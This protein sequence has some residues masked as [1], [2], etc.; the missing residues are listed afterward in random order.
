L[1]DPVQET[2]TMGASPS[3]HPSDQRL[4]AY[5]NGKLDEASA[6]AVSKHLDGCDECLNKVAGIQS[7]SFLGKLRQVHLP[8]VSAAGGNHATGGPETDPGRSQAAPLETEGVP[9]ELAI[10]LDYQIV[11]KLGE[12]GMGVV[13]LARNV[14]M[15][16]D[17]VLKLM[18]STIIER[19]DALDRFQREIRAVARMRHPNI[20][21]AYRAFRAGDR[22]VFAMEYVEG[23]DL[24]RMV[25]ARMKTGKGPLPVANACYYAYQAA[26]ALQHAH[27]HGMVH[28]DIKPANLMLA[29]KGDQ[30]II[31]VLDFGLSKATL[32]TTIL[33]PD[34]PSST[35]ILDGSPTIFGQMLGT[36][37]YIAPEQI[38]DAQSADIRADVY[39][40]GCTLYY[41]LSGRPPFRAQTLYDMLQAHQS[42]SADLLNFVRPEVPTELAA[43]VA[44]MMAKE[45]THRF[46]TPSEVAGALEPFFRKQAEPSLPEPPVDASPP[47][48]APE[49]PSETV[50]GGSHSQDTPVE[51]K[52]VPVVAPQ[53]RPWRRVAMGIGSLSVCAVALGIVMIRLTTRPEPSARATQEASAVPEA[54]KELPTQP[55]QATKPP[56]TTPLQPPEQ[57]TKPPEPPPPPPPPPQ[58]S[59]DPWHLS[60]LGAQVDR[61]VRDG[62]RYLKQ[63]QRPDGAWEDSDQQAKTATTSM[64]TLALMTAG[65]KPDSPLIKKALEHLRLFGPE[66][67]KSTKAIALQTMV[68]AAAEPE[69]DS[70][71][72]AANVSWLESA[73]TKPGQ[74]GAPGGWTCGSSP[75][76]GCNTFTQYALLGLNASSEV[77]V[78]IKP[79]VW[80]LAHLY[81]EN[82]QRSDGGW[83]YHAGDEISNSN[84]TC[85]GVSSLMITGSWTTSPLGSPG[86]EHLQGARI[87]NCGKGTGKAR[88]QQ[89]TGSPSL[90]RGID[91]IAANFNVGQNYPMGQQWKHYYLR[92][93]ALAGRLGGIQFFGQH[94]WYRL[95][96][97]ELVRTQNRLGGD[98]RGTSVEPPVIAT[99]FALLFLAEGPLAEGLLAKRPLAKRRV[100]FL[101]NKL[102]HGP[103]GDWN[104]DPDDVHNL[105]AVVSRDRKSLFTWQ[106]I[107]PTG[108]SVTDLLQ[109]PIV[110]FNGHR[111]PELNAQAKQKLRDYIEQGGFLLADAC[112]S[113]LEFDKGFRSLMREIFPMDGHELRPLP[114]DHPIWK[115]KHRLNPLDHSLDSIELGAR[116]AVIYSSKDLSCY[117]NQADRAP[118]NNAV[119]RA[120]KVG[121]NIVEYATGGKNQPDKLTVSEV[122]KKDSSPAS[123]R[124]EPATPGNRQVK[125]NP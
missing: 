54:T 86:T 47:E 15:G 73:Q 23:V 1:I 59:Q 92:D 115:V 85:A 93:L 102:S 46:Q 11:R 56:E 66:R 98:W 4:L 81:W 77:G 13:Y 7:D 71:R 42:T 69:R 123:D 110:F 94:D 26:Q 89:G 80:E 48:P 58:P 96:A 118:D 87:I 53:G 20:V 27:E 68:F 12:G 64:V 124:K 108:A 79:E 16:R 2:V 111:I 117:W 32:D 75:L 17:E 49:S 78:P 41:M 38:N 95:G 70:M 121:Q 114:H 50:Q 104:H 37:D 22:L 5:G 9:A 45:R 116:T 28:R 30:Q 90:Q 83:G 72:I 122:G 113:S 106:V 3:P 107:D 29:Q 112:C 105:V 84:M 51:E 8:E 99:S 40:L 18:G 62:I 97:E 76:G 109:A 44:K 31:K 82:T 91:W 57:K 35:P 55:E 10:H 101:V 33:D 103:T 61:A 21:T 52:P 119:I 36:P 39:S 24:S 65:E 14:L 6:E 120:M 100:R 25:K 63:Q 74:R 60:P 125:P 88:T 43:L 67:L 19:P 34:Q